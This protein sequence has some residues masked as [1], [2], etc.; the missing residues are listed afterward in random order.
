MS[1][2]RPLPAIVILYSTLIFA[3]VTGA[4]HTTSPYTDNIEILR[5]ETNGPQWYYRAFDLFQDNFPS[6]SD[7]ES[8]VRADAAKDINPADDP[9]IRPGDS[10]VVSCDSPLGGGIAVDG[11]GPRVYMHVKC[12]YLGHDGLKPAQLAGPAL[13][14]TY[15]HYVS[16][17]G[18]WTIIQGDTAM[19][20]AGNPVA[21]L[22]MFDLNDSLFTR[23][24][25]IEYYFKAYDNEGETTTLP[26][27]AET[28]PEYPY[29]NGSYLFEFTCLPTRNT[30]TLYVDHCDGA[31]SWE[32]LEQVYVDATFDVVMPEDIIPDRYDVLAPSSMVGNGLASRARIEHFI[33]GASWGY[34]GIFWDSGDLSTGTMGGGSDW[35]ADKVDDCL[36]LVDYLENTIA[37]YPRYLCIVGEN[38]A[39]E[40]SSYGSPAAQELLGQW[41]G[42]SLV[43]ESFFE[44]TGGSEGGTL[45]P[46]ITGLG[47]GTDVDFYL[48]GGSPGINN[49]DVLEK[50]EAADYLFAYPDYEGQDYYA[51]IC[52]STVNGS[53]VE[54]RTV[55]LGFSYM[56]IRNGEEGM[57]VRNYVAIR[58][59][60][61]CTQMLPSPNEDITGAD[62]PV[63]TALGRSYPNPFNPATMISFDLAA[64]GPV[65]IRI[66]NV[67]G[68]LVR[69]LVNGERG[70]GRHSETWDGKNDAGYLLGSGVY[71]LK[72]KASSFE[73]SRKLV[74]LR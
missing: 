45:N 56:S 67:A 48:D 14:G 44:L 29:Y 36:F 57:P 28:A 32:G 61:C 55:W 72:M 54:V 22:Y 66:Y 65:S 50:T 52:N 23:G 27:N 69:T 33:W 42:V 35:S 1:R 70:A 31:G 2:F 24:Y 51:G 15:G 26:E 41:C 10:I 58:T 8:Y 40:V 21:G 17:D 71:F 60:R 46:F 12:S 30:E 59:G 38:V 7:I 9:S 20:P 64:K 13:E 49:F 18:T 53:G 68:Q 39:A 74:L 16:D 34:K 63:A 4:G 37:D 43:S 73:S 3:A 25:M 11:G 47:C 62:I 19:T 5:Y 6:T